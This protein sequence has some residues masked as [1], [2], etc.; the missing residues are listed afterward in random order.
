MRSADPVA[1]VL[2]W[3]AVVVGVVGAVVLVVGVVGEARR[4]VRPVTGS[5]LAASLSDAVRSAPVGE[6]RCGRRSARWRCNVVDH[7][8]SGG[9]SYEVVLQQDRCWNAVLTGDYSE[10]RDMPWRASGCVARR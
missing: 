8:G 2:R 6:G 10:G 3:V 5:M 4:P 9:A 7:D 1:R